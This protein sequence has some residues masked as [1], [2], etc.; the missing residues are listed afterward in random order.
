MAEF[1]QF[2]DPLFVISSE[3]LQMRMTNACSLI[4]ID[5][6]GW[7]SVEDARFMVDWLNRA[8]PASALETGPCPDCGADGTMHNSHC[9]L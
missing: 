8:I 3:H 5:A 2:P 9:P 7:I 1:T 4:R 6:H